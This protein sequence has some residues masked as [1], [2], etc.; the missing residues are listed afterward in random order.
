MRK[1]KQEGLYMVT[2][3][4]SGGVVERSK[5]KITSRPAKRGGR[6]RGNSSEKKLMGNK[7]HAILQLARIFNC[8]MTAGDLW[9]TATFD[10]ESLE[11]VGGT[12][13]GAKKA[14]KNFI[15]RMV[16][17]LK[18]MGIT[19]RWV[20]APSEID[21]ETGEV[22]RPHV[23]IVITGEGFR[24]QDRQLML[25]EELVEN[26]WGNGTV[27]VQ[28]LRH[29]K[30]YYPLAAYIVNQSRGVPD[31]KKY[32]CSRNMKKPIIRREIVTSGGQLRVPPGGTEL[33]GTKYDPEKGQN[34]VRYIPKQRDPRKK[35]GGSK[36]MAIAMAGEDFDDGGGGD[37]NGLS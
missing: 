31:E 16:Y 4:I 34:F 25:G 18:K 7:A 26:I 23:H 24:M 27:D 1:S 11:K 19:C 9:L 22:V 32:T 3:I 20:L 12:Y 21:G 10:E 2:K 33:P 13:E 37:C 29:Q 30:D 15:D 6:I 35:I 28:F 36:E 17:R 14:G 8:N 5:C